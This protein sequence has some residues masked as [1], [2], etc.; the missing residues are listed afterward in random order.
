MAAL[1][2]V[3]VEVL[4]DV[5]QF[6]DSL[7]GSLRE[8][9]DSNKIA[10]ALTTGFAA[11]S[12]TIATLFVP[13]QKQLLEIFQVGG[14]E[15]TNELFQT[16]SGNVAEIA[17]KVG[18]PS[19]EIGSAIAL[20]L[21]RGFSLEASEQISNFSGQLSVAL[22]QDL[23]DAAK[24]VTAALNGFGLAATETER[25]AGVLFQTVAKSGIP[26]SQLAQQLGNIAPSAS[27]AGV[28]LE[29]VAAA[30]TT[31]VQ[32]GISAAESTTQIR[33]AI[34]ELS[35]A[36]SDGGKVFESISGKTF[37][38][39]LRQGGSLQDAFRLIAAAA[40]KSGYSV[41][42]LTGNYNTANAVVAL[43]GEN[44]RRYTQNLLDNKKGTEDLADAVKTAESGV[45]RQFQRAFTNVRTSV[46]ELG[47]ALAPVIQQITG[48]LTGAI[49][50]VATAIQGLAARIQSTDFTPLITAFQ[51]FGQL[52][53]AVFQMIAGLDWA[54]IGS[55]ILTALAPIGAAFLLAA[56]GAGLLADFINAVLAPAIQAM[57]S[58]MDV[59]APILGGLVAGF[60]AWKV[61]MGITALIGLVTK[62]VAALKAQMLLLNATVR[63]NPFVF[64]ASV[65]VGVGAALVILWKKF[66]WF[67]KA[68]AD[69]VTAVVTGFTTGIDWIVKAI[70]LMPRAWLQ[71]AKAILDS[72][73]HLP[74]WL[75]GGAASQA[76]EAVQGLLNGIDA[77]EQG[78][79]NVTSAARE[80][81][82]ALD[83]MA[84]S[85]GAAGGVVM[86]P[87]GKL[88]PGAA[89]AAKRAKD[90]EDKALYDAFGK[91]TPNL[92]GL[93][94]NTAGLGEL[95]GDDKAGGKKIKDNLSKLVMD[96]YR[97][98]V[99]LA[100]NATKMSVSQIES[101]M[102]TI[103]GKYNKAIEH[104][105]ELGKKG[106]VKRLKDNL[107]VFKAFG[108]QLV[109][110]A[111]ARDKV[112]EK[113]KDAEQALKNIKQEAQNFSDAMK[114]SFVN[115]GSV[116]NV[117]AGI[118]TTFR[119]IRNSIRDAIRTTQDFNKAIQELQAL[120]L[121]ETSL[122]QLADAGPAALEQAQALARSGAEGIKEI[123]GLVAT[124]D[125]SATA[126]ATNLTD[127]FF[128]AGIK[129][130]EGLVKGLKSQRKA[131]IETMEV[132]ADEMVAAVKKGLKIKSPSQVFDELGRQVPAGMAQGVRR[133]TPDVL[134]AIA[135]MSSDKKASIDV[136]GI[137]VTGVADPAAARRAGIL[138]GEGVRS[139]LEKRAVT[140]T[141][142]GVR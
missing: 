4:A 62:G 117:S 58:Q 11:A 107:K 86:T 91:N 44:T 34:T 130:A 104:A 118:D 50:G 26:M 38:E 67:R 41:Q 9:L 119:G 71:A 127:E 5:G 120:G 12:G 55:T 70:F 98:V 28:A 142:S 51:Q 43:T 123:N 1:G 99:K 40:D 56:Q 73:A 45:L 21:G 78:V 64:W 52:F 7:A 18:K 32:Q 139:V 90:A 136:G 66:E 54:A 24:G 19:E 94:P 102:E 85:A 131:I 27:T 10:A 53:G 97:H 129:A 87:A 124:L 22:G 133:G 48:T 125:E 76:A 84:A 77:I 29:E 138:A 57:S 141:L 134:K 72:L 103:I 83:D 31:M 75:G 110:L 15:V 33:T 61:A 128:A 101:S 13:L 116:A 132:I 89:L 108:E 79:N 35:R 74:K 23:P 42:E 14:V 25:V 115:L 69:I 47:I 46:Q 100:K 68:V 63:A 17:R 8:A 59:L 49:S 126:V 114:A 137:T 88:P 65:I 82:R 3:F 80:A 111:K 2:S 93:N 96:I 39:F 105:A 6:E 95:L 106:W 20:G 122:R 113:I 16:L 36:G 92:S 135:A 140:Q 60:V 112:T 121:N 109:K 81:T 30:V 37:P